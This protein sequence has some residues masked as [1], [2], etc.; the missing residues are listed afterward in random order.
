MA[1][2]KRMSRTKIGVV[3]DSSAYA[4]K[5]LENTKVVELRVIKNGKSYK[6]LSEVD[7]DEFYK[8][9]RQNKELPTTSAAPIEEVREAVSSLLQDNDYVIGIWLSKFFSVTFE[10]AQ[11][12]EKEFNGRFL[13]FDTKSVAA[14][15]YRMILE[16][17][18]AI[19]LGWSLDDV[20]N[21]ITKVRDSYQT[22][23]LA[24]I[25]HLAR[26]GRIGKAQALAGN[27]LRFE[28]LLYVDD[29][30]VNSYKVIRGRK[31]AIQE[32]PKFMIKQFGNEPLLLDIV[33]AD[34]FNE[35]SILED[36]LAQ[37][38]MQR[39]DV[40]RLGP[41]IGTHLGPDLLA[42]FGV[43]QKVLL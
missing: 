32:M 23:F 22:I 37:N 1:G 7:W 42:L 36:L 8:D 10:E 41:V 13:C 27:L 9:L 35:V 43:P 34:N 11:M 25:Q 2:G 5:P 15:P 33:W 20:M 39:K 26:G 3:F 38:G 19:D 16:A 30:E 21:H 17:L 28:P 6:E 31:A 24:S 4:P 14:G 29:G 40:L 18:K 12:L